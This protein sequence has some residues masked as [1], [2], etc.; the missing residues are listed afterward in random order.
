MSQLAASKITLGGDPE[1]LLVQITG[2]N[3]ADLKVVPA[4]LYMPNTTTEPGWGVDGCSATAEARLRNPHKDAFSLTLEMKEHMGESLKYLPLDVKLLAGSGTTGKDIQRN[5]YIPT[6]GH[7]HIGMVSHS[8]MKLKR[9]ADV[10]DLSLMIPLMFLEDP[11]RA[12]IRRNSNGGRYGNLYNTTAHNITEGDAYRNKSYGMEYRSPSSWLVSES[13]TRSTFALAHAI[14]YDLELGKDLPSFSSVFGTGPEGVKMCEAHMRGNRTPF[15]KSLKPIYNIIK[16][17]TLFKNG[18]YTDQIAGL[19]GL[20]MT[21]GQ[22]GKAWKE[23]DCIHSAWGFKRDFSL[24][25]ASNPSYDLVGNT[26]D[27]GVTEIL[28]KFA[29]KRFKK[30]IW[31]YGIANKHEMNFSLF[32]DFSN[33]DINPGFFSAELKESRIPIQSAHCWIGIARNVRETATMPYI[34]E[35]ISKFLEKLVVTE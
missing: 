23:D 5:S 6:G 4:S 25:M 13:F 10:L 29:G 12:K 21:F 31:V 16:D 20:A 9:Y 27:Q 32:G 18:K 35:K 14:A 19:M 3:P 8:E 11:A 17:L 24:A 30:K 7:I 33:T 34:V 26:A 22:S 2:P 28:Q 15:L 1:G